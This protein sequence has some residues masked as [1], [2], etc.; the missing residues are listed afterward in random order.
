MFVKKKILLLL[1]LVSKLQII[2]SIFLNNFTFGYLWYNI[3]PNSLIGFQKY[4]EKNSSFVFF[5]MMSLY[6]IVFIFL[7]TNV[8]LFSGIL[9]IIILCFIPIKLAKP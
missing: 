9:L 7:E 5:K 2:I 4:V 3:H 8:L 6:D 1:F